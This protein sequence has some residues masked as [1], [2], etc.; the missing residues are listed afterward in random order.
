M[1][2]PS[3]TGKVPSIVQSLWQ[4]LRLE[5]FR[6]V[7]EALLIAFLITTF[8]FTT[9]GVVGTSDLPNLQPGE[10]VFIPKY[11]TWLQRFG[12]NQLRRGDL[13]VVKPPLSSPY[14]VQAFPV[15]G[16]NFRPFF[17]KRLVG[18]PGDRIRLE[19]GQLF[20]NGTAIDESH[21]VPY[22]KALG[23]L[24]EDSHLANSEEWP[25]RQGQRGEFTVPEGMYFVMGDNRSPGGSEDSRDFGPVSLS[26][27]GGRASFRLWPPLKRDAQGQWKLNWHELETPEGFTIGR[28]NP[29]R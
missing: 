1:D 9:V 15:L 7:G 16:F 24:D 8:L 26:Q 28:G 2:Q 4:Y 23:Q 19:R 18:L 10:R 5:W 3:Q 12:S 25:F 11:Q 29:L 27:I 20:I 14:A 22:W 21:T 13:V 17:I 6:Q